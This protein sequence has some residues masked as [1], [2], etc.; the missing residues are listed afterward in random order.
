MKYNLYVYNLSEDCAKK[1]TAKKLAKFKLVKNVKSLRLIPKNAIFLNPIA[2]K[3]ISPEQE[4]ALKKQG[5]GRY[6]DVFAKTE[7]SD[8]QSDDDQTEKPMT[9]KVA[10]E[11]LIKEF[12][13]KKE[14]FNG[15]GKDDVL[16]LL[17]TEVENK[18]DETSEG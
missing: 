16:S 1:C 5:Y 15:L 18:G 8:G 4:E 12:S 3:A 2:K 11:I 10:M 13:Y 14:D 7:S 9:K 17:K 6:E